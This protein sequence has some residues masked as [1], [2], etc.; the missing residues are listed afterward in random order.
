MHSDNKLN[1]A[2]APRS[3]VARREE[4]SENDYKQ[5]GA[6]HVDYLHALTLE[7]AQSPRATVAS[8]PCGLESWRAQARPGSLPVFGND[9]GDM[10]FH[11]AEADC[12]TPVVIHA[13]GEQ[14]M[15]PGSE[16]PATR[17]AP[18][19][20]SQASLVLRGRSQSLASLPPQL[21]S[22]VIVRFLTYV[23]AL[24]LAG[25]RS[26]IRDAVRADKIVQL[27]GPL[28]PHL[29]NVHTLKCN[30]WLPP[31]R[32]AAA[33]QG[34]EDFRDYAVEYW[35]PSV[36]ALLNPRMT[37]GQELFPERSAWLNELNEWVTLIAAN[38]CN[39]PANELMEFLRKINAPESV[40]SGVR[41]VFE[42]ADVDL[43]YSQRGA[44]KTLMLQVRSHLLQGA[45]DAISTTLTGHAV[46]AGRLGPQQPRT[47]A[48][49]RSLAH[50]RP[51]TVNVYVLASNPWGMT[52]D[53]I[54]ALHWAIHKY[55]KDMPQW[56]EAVLTL[57]NPGERGRPPLCPEHLTMLQQ[58]NAWMDL[59]NEDASRIPADELE[60]LM[61]RVH[62]PERVR[63]AVSRS[64]MTAQGN[65]LAGE[66]GAD[67]GEMGNGDL[68][69]GDPDEG[70]AGLLQ[71][72]LVTISDLIL[73][74][75]LNTVSLMPTKQG[76][77]SRP[78]RKAAGDDAA[79][80]TSTDAPTGRRPPQAGP[81]G[82][83]DMLGRC[84]QWYT[85]AIV[86]PALIPVE[87][88]MEVMQHAGADANTQSQMR[89]AL[90]GSSYYD[91]FGED[92]RYVMELL[93]KT[94]NLLV[95]GAALDSSQGPA[96]PSPDRAGS[97]SQP[98]NCG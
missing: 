15:Q 96:Q 66:D 92:A 28:A 14:K 56:Q 26:D 98:S 27:A 76:P 23:E 81:L 84:E 51:H 80:P 67:E 47:D 13:Q 86:Q 93:R 45:F 78:K 40:Q 9:L 42:T 52:W 73:L 65:A 75:A 16:A 37:Y 85:W 32:L 46:Q 48:T 82:H 30:N 29:M 39:R 68:G 58:C 4:F 7:Q 88:V 34:I 71:D 33:R 72:N 94:R 87:E 43:N 69:E 91:P 41:K 60:A 31:G 2:Y 21:I 10:N 36:L 57:M 61:H 35:T 97:P 44:L 20:A 54:E 3:A 11:G 62:T 53:R 22:P 70:D 12:N 55:R 89:D 17:A 25:T 50:L 24:N 18:R 95:T 6:A 1:P 83:Q 5:G 38:E 79:Q 49:A 63:A 90:A 8:T 77:L 74:D 19:A 59:A 64:L